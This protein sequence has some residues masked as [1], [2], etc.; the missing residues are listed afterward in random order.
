MSAMDKM[1]NSARGLRGRMKR[2]AG[3]V[4]GNVQMQAEGQSEEMGANAAQAGEKLKDAV[5]SVVPGRR[6]RRRL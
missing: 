2:N 4:T 6:R 1:R 5:R 3:E